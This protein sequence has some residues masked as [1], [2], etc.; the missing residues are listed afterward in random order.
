MKNHCDI[1]KVTLT[2]KNSETE[3]GGLHEQES[4]KGIFQSDIRAVS[5][6]F[7]RNKADHFKRIL[8]Q[9]WVQSEVCYP[10]IKWPHPSENH[11]YTPAPKETYLR[12]GGF[13][14]FVCCM[15]GSGLSLFS[16]IK[17]LD[18][19]LVAV[20]TKTISAQ[21]AGRET[22]ALDQRPSDGQKAQRQESSSWQ[23]YV[24]SD[25]N[26]VRLAFMH[27]ASTSPFAMLPLLLSFRRYLQTAIEPRYL[28][29]MSFPALP[30]YIRFPLPRPRGF[31]EPSAAARHASGR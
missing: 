20:D 1:Y 25:N 12:A 15:G 4:D 29:S 28:F 24:C 14:D 7:E 17:S 8:F 2:T 22:V 16:K 3:T 10:E 6:G 31:P 26:R 27:L 18:K 11:Y 21:A 5:E 30:S 13:I 19:T 9:Y 23:T